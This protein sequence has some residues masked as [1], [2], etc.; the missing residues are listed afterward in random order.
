MRKGIIALLLCVFAVS[1]NAQVSNEDVLKRIEDLEKQ[2]EELKKDAELKDDDDKEEKEEKEDKEDKE[3]KEKK[4]KE[5]KAKEENKEK[6]GKGKVIL[7][8]FV[9]FNYQTQGG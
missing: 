6:K 2:L 5:E 9:N 8:G 7:R 1:V 4:I 3:D